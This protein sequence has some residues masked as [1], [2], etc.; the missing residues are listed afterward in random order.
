VSV[1]AASEKGD[2]LFRGRTPD[3]ALASNG[4]PQ[5]PVAGAATKPQKLVFDVPPGK[6]ELRLTVE[7][8]NGGG[9]LD[10]EI[11]TIDAPDFT[12]PQV[13]LSTPSVFHA[14]TVPEFRTFASDPNAAPAA[15]RE[16]SRT[17]R[18]LIRFNTYGPGTEKPTPTATLLNRA[19]QKMAD[20]PVA[21]AATGTGYQIDLSLNTIPPGE[22]LVEIGAKGPS[23][24]AKELVPFRVTG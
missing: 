2:L 19:G 24:E 4:P 23:G 3:A 1:L 17:E 16:F 11:R 14:R 9:T 20:V 15:V 21:P 12:G 10:Q 6:V 8:A 18:L 7:G 13:A 22:Y 5:L